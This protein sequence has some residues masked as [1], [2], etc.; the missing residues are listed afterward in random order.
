M[1]MP[2]RNLENVAEPPPQKTKAEA[3]KQKKSKNRVCRTLRKLQWQTNT[4]DKQLAATL[5]A[6]RE[7]VDL[8]RVGAEMPTN[9]KESD[10]TLREE[11]GYLFACSYFIDRK[12]EVLIV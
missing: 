2:L 6:I 3:C 11:V 1:A 10:R 4:S 9:I 5:D 12:T 7:I 8:L